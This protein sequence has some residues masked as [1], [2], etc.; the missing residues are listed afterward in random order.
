MR[1]PPRTGVGR[2][3]LARCCR[4]SPC[5]ARLSSAHILQE[6]LRSLAHGCTGLPSPVG[7][8]FALC[9]A[10]FFPR[11]FRKWSCS[12][13]LCFLR[14]FGGTGAVGGPG[15]MCLA[16][17]AAG[18]RRG[19]RAAT[20]PAPGAPYGAGRGTALLPAPGAAG[21]VGQRLQLHRSLPTAPG[22]TAL[23]H[24]AGSALVC[25]PAPLPRASRTCGWHLG[26]G[27]D[28]PQHA[29]QVV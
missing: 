6:L 25:A 27:E 29:P 7:F 13:F 23:P 12:F 5:A 15:I 1:S 19:Q 9:N 18:G 11:A 21:A 4:G 3:H 16:G 24:A 20:S 8:G 28:V 10:A 14:W 17:R 2:E 26:G 22:G